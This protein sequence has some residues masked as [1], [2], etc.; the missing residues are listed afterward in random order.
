MAFRYRAATF[1]CG[2]LDISAFGV[3]SCV[4][5]DSLDGAVFYSVTL[6]PPGDLLLRRLRDAHRM[7]RRMPNA[8]AGTVDASGAL[9]IGLRTPHETRLVTLC[10]PREL[11][12]TCPQQANVIGS[13]LTR[14]YRTVSSWSTSPPLMPSGETSPGSGIE[15]LEVG[16]IVAERN[17][18]GGARV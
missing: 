8:G 17:L 14:N 10:A 2:L 1:A 12:A 7:R 11:S 13:P 18:A 16:R 3:S 9:P 15:S 5:E 4:A 6:I